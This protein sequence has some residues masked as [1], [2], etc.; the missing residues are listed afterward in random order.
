MQAEIVL[1]AVGAGKTEYALTQI[2]QVVQQK[3][4]A[5]VW[6]LLATERQIQRFRARL[7]HFH[8]E[9]ATY[10]NVNFFTF[11]DLYPW[12]LQAGNQPVR[13]LSEPAR[14][15][16]LRRIIQEM[17]DWGDLDV[18]AP[19]A[20]RAGFVQTFATFIYE[21]K[22]ALVDE[23]AFADALQKVFGQRPKDEELAKIYRAY[24]GRLRTHRVV[25][26]EGEGWLALSAM[27]DNP[28]LLNDLDLLVVD[29]YDQFRP[30]QLQLVAQLARRS[31]QTVITL[32]HLPDREQT[33]GRRFHRAYQE[34][35]Q[36]LQAQ[37]VPLQTHTLTE[38]VERR[39]VDLQTLAENVFRL[40]QSSVPL[41]GGVR[42]INAPDLY[43]GQF[44]DPY[45]AVGF[46]G[47]VNIAEE[48]RAVM[49]EV[50]R[51]LL[52]NEHGVS[53]ARPDDMIIV[54]R[55]YSRYQLHLQ[56]IARQYR[57]PIVAHLGQTLSDVPLV[58]M[59][60]LVLTLHDAQLHTIDFPRRELFDVLRSPYFRFDGLDTV[61][62]DTLDK[63]SREL[64]IMG[65]RD[66]WLQSIRM[67]AQERVI[68]DEDS[69][70]VK[71][72]KPLIEPHI[73]EQ[74]Y[75]TLTKFFDAIT[76]PDSSLLASYV[77]WVDNLIGSDAK[78]DP[79]DGDPNLQ[80]GILRVIEAIHATD[81]ATIRNRDLSAINSF[82]SVLRGLLGAQ[83]LL[84]SLKVGDLSVTWQDFFIDLQTAVQQTSIESRP[85]RSGRVL[86]T[87]VTDARGLPHQH[88][89]IMGLSEGLFP[90]RLPEDPLYLDS[91]RRALNQD[92]G[93]PLDTAQILAGDEGL[94]YEMMSLARESL[95]L[96]R[97]MVRDGNLWVESHLWRAVADVFEGIPE[98]LAKMTPRLGQWVALEQSATLNEVAIS[99]AA[100]YASQP[101][102][103]L[104][105]KQSQ[106]WLLQ[107][108]DKLWANVVRGYLAEHDRMVNRTHSRYTGLIQ[109]PLLREKLDDLLGLR[110]VWSASQLNDY[111]TCPFRFFA[112]RVL[113]LDAIEE[114]QYGM[115]NLQLGGLN[116]YILECT[117]R[118]FRDEKLDITPENFERAS[119]ILQENAEREL[120]NAPDRFGFR[121]TPI[122]EQEKDII[123]N[124]LHDLLKFDFVELNAALEKAGLS[125]DTRRT[126]ETELSF[127][128]GGKGTWFY[129]A[130]DESSILVRGYIDR[131]DRMGDSVI[132]FDYKTGS[133]EI[134]LDELKEGRNFQIMFYLVAMDDILKSQQGNVDNP[135]K[136]VLGGAFWHI[137]SGK[138]SG[139][140]DYQDPEHVALIENARQQIGAYIKR[141]QS[142][143]F[144]VQ[145][146]RLED[147][148]CS[149]YCAY[150]RFC[151][152]AVTRL[153]KKM[154]S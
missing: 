100:D 137:K 42:L 141:A 115:D 48:S 61:A 73:A 45:A 121:V 144:A 66:M 32:T 49:R 90:M 13:K 102:A 109:S 19:I 142:G 62:I 43:S 44:D 56:M 58:H 55:D 105:A 54:L 72:I 77:E 30:L 126:Y 96:S 153:N 83:A 24:Q 10:F 86:M 47:A 110:H 41:Q 52:P 111:G 8:P 69:D 135:P 145:P 140:L 59:L 132:V 139:L 125:V 71:L 116:H 18:F 68:G 37:D 106:N 79:E 133:K 103:S 6:V 129:V 3:P 11:Y 124:R 80:V 78:L 60:L 136:Q 4:F 97:P 75:V 82:K 114:P 22:S 92:G 28:D 65:G 20:D 31:T 39:H 151:R 117:Y 21:L 148:R 16:L 7:V 88:V 17:I 40:Q 12:I 113:R 93:I 150:S 26:R 120:K 89:F 5:K 25:D 23:E 27:Q 122:W 46:I 64:T 95:T 98:Q 149:R 147:G 87:T 104:Q 94:F 63:I 130:E 128:I 112:G 1:A 35:E 53:L 51:L 38:T 91:E 108:D 67:A 50:K 29:G 154:P 143:D 34:I 101:T 33:V 107:T 74:L 152:I 84:A 118:Q 123:M 99:V 9:N 76:P 15:R 2:E 70:D 81:N 127:G 146:S 14:F 57:V 36:V 119:Q 85:S 131:I 138:L 134:S